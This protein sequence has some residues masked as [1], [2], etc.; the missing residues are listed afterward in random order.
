MAK[1]IYK[2]FGIL[3]GVL[4]G[5]LAGRA[6]ERIWGLVSEDE[7]ADAEDREAGWGE[8]LSSAAIHGAVYG[9]VQALV[10]RS[11]AKGFERATGI[12]PGSSG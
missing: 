8:V 10:R 4:A 7:P 3:V 9:L 2:P 1:L 12:W 5:V 6:F 11:G